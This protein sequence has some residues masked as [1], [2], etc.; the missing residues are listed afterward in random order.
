LALHRL[1]EDEQHLDRAFA[2]AENSK[3]GVL[4][5]AVNEVEA[6]SFAGIRREDLEQ[7]HRLRLD[8]AAS[9]HRLTEAEVEKGT[10]EAKLQALRD[11]HLGL[12]R[13][14]DAL[15][16]RL[17]REYPAYY[18]LKYRF[19]TVRPAE[20]RE[21]LLDPR[22]ALVEYFLGRD[23]IFIFTV[24][25]ESVE[26]S[27]VARDTSF[28]ADLHELR[29]AIA[30]RDSASH[31]PSA[32][33]LYD[34][35]LAPVASRLAGK[36][37]VLVPDG[38]LSIV[39]FEALLEGEAG[40]S[41]T[42]AAELP[43]VLRDHAVSYAYSA[44]LLL[45]GLR[46]KRESPP[47]EL[48]AFAPVFAEGTAPLPE[49]ALPLPA[50]REE[51]SEVR[52]RVAR[53]QGFFGGWL[54]GRSRVYLDEDATEGRLKSADL[55]RYRFVHLATHGIV[56]EEH[57]GLSRL[58]LRPGAGPGEDGVL[59]LGEIYNLRM[60]ADLV[61]LSACDTGLGRI[62]RGE[63]I[64]GLTRGFLYAG[65]RSVLVSLWPVSDVATSSLVVDFYSELLAGRTKAEALRQAKL[66]TMARN[67]EL[68]KPYYWSSLVLVGQ[69]R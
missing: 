3:A 49:A 17:E 41:S 63:G 47:D 60:N 57:P 7:E 61:V 38:G 58:L 14:Y 56:D 28:E 23:Q 21:G 54:R 37:L 15:R 65:A 24:T 27:Q 29:R 59:H 32:R 9:D 43:Y 53:R 33:R 62:A 40:P 52:R 12:K 11:R 10:D 45:Q 18:D 34:L 31:D 42:E 36:D 48:I 20:I 64:I 13:E 22:T 50:S 67:P 35:L 6:R 5:D 4:R 2:Y 69:G 30:R 16:Q 51:V 1:T 44:T 8:L 68:A 26:V 66:K 46:Q 39:P 19:D 55:E 25:T